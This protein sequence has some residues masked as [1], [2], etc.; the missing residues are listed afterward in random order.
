MTDVYIHAA[1][2][3]EG[4]E[5]KLEVVDLITSRKPPLVH[6]QRVVHLLLSASAMCFSSSSEV[7][8]STMLC[9]SLLTLVAN[10][11]KTLRYS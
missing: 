1:F 8:D 3:G 6:A 2:M 7:L 11:Y 5:G 9:C 10:K 4:N